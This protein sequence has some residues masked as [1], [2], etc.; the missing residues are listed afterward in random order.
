MR[1]VRALLRRSRCQTVNAWRVVRAQSAFK[2]L[3]VLAFAVGCEA[4]LWAL[5]HDGFRYL[6]SFGG[7][8]NLIVGRLLSLFFLGMG[9]MLVVSAIVTTY[10]TFFRSDEIA[11]L[12]VRPFTVSQIVTFKFLEAT[13]LSSWAFFFI[14]IPFVGAYG[15]YFGTGLLFTLWTFVLAFPFL[16]VCS[17]VGAFIVLLLV[18]WF[19]RGLPVK[20][21]TLVSVAGVLLSLLWLFRVEKPDP[22]AFTLNITRLVPGLRL[23]TYPLLPSQWMAGGIAA[24]TRREWVRGG[25]LALAL[26]STAGAGTLLVEWTG[27]HVYY[28]AWQRV[29]GSAARVERKPRLLSNLDRVMRFLPG[30]IRAM[31]M[32]DI[33][34]FLRDPMQWSQALIFF[35]LLGLY[36]GNLRSFKYHMFP[37]HWQNTITFLNI[38]SVSAV[39]CSL[40]SRFV[41]PQ[42]SL[43]GQG[44]WILGLSPTTPRRILR[45]K[46]LT[47]LLAMLAVSVT[48][49]HVSCTMLNVMAYTRGVATVLVVAMSFAV[50]GLSTGLGA[51]FL[52][53]RQRNPAAIVSG[54]GGT[55]N[56]VL[57]LGFM[58]ASVLPPALVLHWRSMGCVPLI[59]LHPALALCVAWIILLT[60]AVTFV[61]LWLGRRSLEARDY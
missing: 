56:L 11:F 48:L 22:N 9:L 61:P 34:S 20:V 13:L 57:T 6:D 42:L 60:V 43:E 36:F 32:K 38:F 7:A 2:W 18:R 10:A 26:L 4:G 15:W 59:G 1:G 45:T 14:I 27:R 35:G 29:C 47:A 33:R 51:V 5:F 40:G 12:M 25:M 39:M 21:M 54:F 3:F 16:V 31:V 44:F 30:D 55:L 8:G 50:A 37:G 58:L 41:Y 19:P 28:A 49:I 52:D 23:A 17:T 24:L 53:L 46:F